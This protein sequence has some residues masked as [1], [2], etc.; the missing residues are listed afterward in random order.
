M[1]I[2]KTV[3]FHINYYKKMHAKS[4]QRSNASVLE[5]ILFYVVQIKSTNFI[6][7][8]IKSYSY[9][10]YVYSRDFM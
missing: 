9:L 3:Y 7:N 1:V 10:F 4:V 8:C 5:H 6:I 2:P